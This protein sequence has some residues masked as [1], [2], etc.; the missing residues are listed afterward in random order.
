MQPQQFSIESYEVTN[1]E[2]IVMAEKYNSAIPVTIPK[3]K[4][5]WWLRL[6]DKL[7][8]ELNTSDHQGEH[9]QFFGTM[10]LAEYWDS[11]RD[12]KSVV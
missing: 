5:E 1:D 10:S 6:E 4:F 2:V 11:D 9:H 3:D 12:R 8:W 7:N